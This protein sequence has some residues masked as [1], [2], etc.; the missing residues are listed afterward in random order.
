MIRFQE[1]DL[2]TMSLIDRSI[3]CCISHLRV[4]KRLYIEAVFSVG[5]NIFLYLGA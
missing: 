4:M 1:D 3:D 2:S 5:S